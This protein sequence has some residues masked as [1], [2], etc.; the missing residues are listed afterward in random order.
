[1]VTESLLPLAMQW[2]G[3]RMADKKEK[4]ETM[5]KWTV[6]EL[7]NRDEYEQFDDF[8]EMVHHLLCIPR[9]ALPPPRAPLTPTPRSQL[10]ALLQVI[11][12]GYITFFASAFPLASAV[13][14]VCN[15]I[16]MRS[17]IFKLSFLCQR[18]PAM[19]AAN[20]GTWE[21]VLTVQV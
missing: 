14:I 21:Y 18:P 5:T 2:V 7:S 13:S 3:G 16:E 9:T 20:I 11:E 8:L 10:C 17:D 12:F 1:M 4:K 19:Q 6:L 15:L